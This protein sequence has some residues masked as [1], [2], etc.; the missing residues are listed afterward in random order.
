[1]VSEAKRQVWNDL[2]EKSTVGVAHFIASGFNL[3]LNNGIT[4]PGFGRG[5][6][7]WANNISPKRAELWI[8]NPS[9]TPFG[10]EG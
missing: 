5:D 10:V 2:I 1:M 3:R 6:I 8:S 9:S 4:I 7:N